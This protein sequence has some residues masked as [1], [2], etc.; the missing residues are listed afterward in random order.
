MHA[1]TLLLPVLCLAE[2]DVNRPAVVVVVGAPGSE[3]YAGKFSQWA[4]NWE[5]AAKKAGADF[6]R[7]GPSADKSLPDDAN[8]GETLK[9]TLAGFSNSSPESVWLVLIG[10]GTFDG[11]KAK[12]NLRGPDVTAE[13]LA[14]WIKPLSMPLAII[15]CASS[16][17]PF[18]NK[19][20]GPDR[21]V[22]TSTKSGYEQNYSRFGEYISR[23][24]ADENADLDK[25]GQT[26]LLE[27]YLS[28]SSAVQDFYKQE[29]RL[30]TENALIDDNGDGLGTPADW[31]QGYRAV[32]SAKDGATPDGSRATQFVLIQSA[33]ED[34]LSAEM[35]RKR[36]AL[37]LEIA[38]LR[39]RKSQLS[40]EEYYRGLEPLLL[41]LA[42]LY[43]DAETRSATD[44]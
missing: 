17:G 19:L 16:S 2:P 9:E 6:V 32:R 38:G 26:S 7:I 42:R 21:V 5:A 24:I 40:E 28:A 43:R 25:D 18:I 12:F 41:E 8:D 29:S 4:E 10:H 34:N 15:N 39:A 1:L 33:E 44:E 31:F 37:E 13:E 27:A 20:S 3:E 23:S 11:R 14:E 36:D 22:V 35:R 30:A